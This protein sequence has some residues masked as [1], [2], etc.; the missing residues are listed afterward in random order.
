MKTQ[1]VTVWK[2]TPETN[3]NQSMLVI[4]QSDNWDDALLLAQQV[5]PFEFRKIERAQ[6]AHYAP[7]AIEEQPIIELNEFNGD[8][9]EQ[10]NK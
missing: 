9:L 2:V 7:E 5:V 4:T 6:Y 3:H 1:Q 10:Q 8:E